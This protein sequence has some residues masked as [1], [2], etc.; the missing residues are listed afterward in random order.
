MILHGR[1][2]ISYGV[3]VMLGVGH[4]RAHLHRVAQRT[5]REL[6]GAR[7]AGAGRLFCAGHVGGDGGG[8]GGGCGGGGV[9]I[10]CG[11]SDRWRR[12]LRFA[13][14]A[15]AEFFGAV[16]EEGEHEGHDE[17]GAAGDDERCD[18]PAEVGGVDGDDGQ[19]DEL[20]RGAVR[21]QDA[22]DEASA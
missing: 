14:A 6:R 13:V 21:R 17:E 8:G 22:G 4:E 3:Q 18:A 19:E 5:D 12:R 20:P 1:P 9:G 15:D 16:A 7:R 2:S 11:L 10:R